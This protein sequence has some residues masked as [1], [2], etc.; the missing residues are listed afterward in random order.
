[1]TPLRTQVE[2]EDNSLSEGKMIRTV[3]GD[4]SVD[5]LAGVCNAH[6]H[7][8][9]RGDW[10]Q[11]HFAAFYRSNAKS[12][13]PDLEAFRAAG[14]G[15]LVDCTPPGAGRDAQVLADT[16]R[17]S[18]LS[19]IGATGRHLP[20]YYHPDS[21]LLAMDREALADLFI[22][23]ITQGMN[24]GTGKTSFQ[25]GVIKIASSRGDLNEAE[26]ELF[27]A[28]GAAQ[29]TTGCPIITHTEAGTECQQQIDT[30]VNHG[31]ALDKVTL[32]HCDKNP[33]IEFHRD[34]LQTG[35]RLEYDQHFR[36]L[37]RQEKCATFALAATLS[38]DFPTQLVVGMDL[39][40]NEYWN[41]YD[42]APGLA[43]LVSE[44][45]NL[46][47]KSGVSNEAIQRI[48][49]LNALEAFSFSAL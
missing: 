7:I 2:Q 40:R 33:D 28:A 47:Y 14:G 32:S 38:E 6:E 1:M 35:V 43:W 37:R 36:Y 39:A 22:N 18:G 26:R 25:A 8:V 24:D 12:I 21:S 10:M 31:A 44:L 46:L 30:L 17:L 16:S 9:M 19:I 48:T 49:T 41:G 11:Q 45:P 42:G 3:L 13:L 23:E 20:Q 5:N 15:W 29:A 34:L 27:A 4:V